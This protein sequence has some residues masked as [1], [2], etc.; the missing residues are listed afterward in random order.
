LERSEIQGPYLFIIKTIYRKTRANIKLSGQI[1][2]AI[3]LKSGE[4][5]G[6]PLPDIYLIKY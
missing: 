6:Y 5:Q 1:L 3:P 2:E 4:R